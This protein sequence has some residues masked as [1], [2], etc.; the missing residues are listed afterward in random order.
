MSKL[1]LNDISNIT[2]N[3]TSAENSL[4]ANFTAIETALENTLSRDGTT[5]NFW[6]AAQD[7]NSHRLVNLPYAL[8]ATEP[9]TLAQAMALVTG[10]DW[11]GGLGIP[12]VVFYQDNEPPAT[13]AG[14]VWVRTSDLTIYVWDGVS[15]VYVKDPNIQYAVDLANGNASDISALTGRVIAVEADSASYSQAIIEL[16]SDTSS[17]AGE[18]VTITAD[19]GNNTAAI[20]SEALARVD[21]DVALATAINT[22][23]A[24]NA[25]IFIQASAPVAGVGGVPDPIPDGSFWYDSD[26]GNAQYRWLDGAWTSVENGEIAALQAQI[27]SEQS[28]RIDGDSALAVDVSN[29]WAQRNADYVT[30]T[31]NN[32]ARIDGDTALGS[33]ISATNATV[34]AL[35]S[36]V[37]TNN[38]ARISGDSA[39]SSQISSTNT[40]VGT[41]ST[42][43]TQNTSSINGIQGKY[44]IKIDSNGY[45]TGFGLVATNNNST[46]TSTFTVLANNFKIVTP[47]SAAVSPFYVTGGVTYIKNVII[48]EAAIGTATIGTST[49][50]T[51]AVSGIFTQTY[52]LGNQNLSTPTINVWYPLTTVYG[53][54]VISVSG[55]VTPYTK[56]LVRT[57]FNVS[58]SGGSAEWGYMRL[59]RDD[60]VVLPSQLQF[61][62]GTSM[63]SY[64]WEWVDT[65]PVSASHTYAVEV[66]RT[67]SSGTNFGEWA[68]VQMVAT[69]IKR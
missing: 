7:A 42:T 32:V 22:L 24:S 68:D 13:A 52:N 38:E 27:T 67:T 48:D 46:P 40:T 62:F 69:V 56:V 49:I 64:S 14:Q 47:G 4:N 44:S 34:G 23:Q 58:Q 1:V 6:E 18:I 36:T 55:I 16:Q 3:P 63:L 45:V 29:L 20:Q 51:D 26:D 15:W 17:M 59:V 41:L 30:I 50:K 9:V 43:V 53:T 11:T 33:Q 54:A 8:S 66:K 25:Q 19:V 28:A 65:N 39:L 57:Y 31:D 10:E 12:A 2:G 35:S 37:T 61:K 60:G 5:P 21:G